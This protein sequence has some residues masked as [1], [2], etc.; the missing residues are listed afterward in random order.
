MS[1]FA[2]TSNG[3]ELHTS[4]DFTKIWV[5]QCLLEDDEKT[6]HCL[7]QK[8]LLPLKE[9]HPELEIE[10]IEVQTREAFLDALERI[11]QRVEQTLAVPVIHLE[12]HGRKDR[13]DL[14]HSEHITY[15]ELM[16]KLREINVLAQNSLIL[17]SAACKGGH[18]AR[19]LCS[20]L[21]RPA[22]IG[23]IYG[24]FEDVLPIVVYESC[25]EFYEQ[26][27]RT[28]NVNCALA[29]VE[30]I[31]QSEKQRFY[32]RSSEWYFLLGFMS[33]WAKVHCTD[34]VDRRASECAEQAL[35]QCNNIGADFSALKEEARKRLM[36]KEYLK[37]AFD[38]RMDKFFEHDIDNDGNRVEHPSFDVVYAMFE[39]LK[40]DPEM[41][42]KWREAQS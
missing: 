2:T 18:F 15:A 36:S 1:K 5:I 20:D 29:R 19:V 42:R 27:V 34:Y 4:V 31:V 33:F 8:V 13:F 11:R 25:K 14:S 21:R 32:L 39:S 3:L 26:L 6:G 22:P 23:A 17:V 10:F 16:P 38:K 12:T 37:D 24:P 41:C 9:E 40:S 7:Y 30:N 35:A 28:R